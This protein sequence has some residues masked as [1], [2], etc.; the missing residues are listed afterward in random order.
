MKKFSH[1]DFKYKTKVIKQQIKDNY[2]VKLMCV[3]AIE[4]NAE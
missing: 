1:Q 2:D 4:R 3:Y